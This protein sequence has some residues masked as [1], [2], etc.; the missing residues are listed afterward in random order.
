MGFPKGISE[1]R[2]AIIALVLAIL[3]SSGIMS[4]AT[5]RE[6]AQ[7]TPIEPGYV[8]RPSMGFAMQLRP[9]GQIEVT[10]VTKGQGADKG[11]MRL[12]DILVAIGGCPIKK[13]IDVL[14]A[15]AKQEIGVLIPVAVLRDGA[16]VDLQ[17]KTAFADWD[18]VVLFVKGLL[19][20][21]KQVSLAIM[22]GE[23]VN[24]TMTDPLQLEQWSK[25]IKSNLIAESEERFTKS[26]PKQSNF[27]VVD[28]QAVERV[29][30]EL[31]FGQTGMVSEEH[32]AKLGKLLGATHLMIIEFSRFGNVDVE[33]QRLIEVETGKVLFSTKINIPSRPSNS[34]K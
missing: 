22:C 12:G 30:K 11:G 10:G 1:M 18:G 2:N 8:R 5:P 27:S 25:G 32:R 4:A 31:N 19:Y 15:L 28:R 21:E 17:I 7:T 6:K 33:K 16:K 20:E 34:Q 26:L 29:L 14:D 13:R 9:D 24:V 3:A 23:A